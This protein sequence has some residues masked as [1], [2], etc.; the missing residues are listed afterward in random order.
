MGGDRQFFSNENSGFCSGWQGLSTS[1]EPDTLVTYRRNFQVPQ[2][3]RYYLQYQTHFDLQVI[4]PENTC[5]P[6]KYLLL[7]NEIPELPLQLNK[8]RN[9]V[10][11][12]LRNPTLKPVPGDF[13]AR[14][15]SENGTIVF[16]EIRCPLP[17]QQA[18]AGEDDQPGLDGFTPATGSAYKSCG[19]FGYTKGDGIL[20]CSMAAF[21]MITRP[22]VSGHPAFRKNVIW[23]L[24]LLPEGE[25]HPC[26]LSE[27][28]QPEAGETLQ[29]DWA[30]VRWGRTLLNG[31]RM[32][33]D[34]S[35]LTPEILIETEAKL[36]HLNELQNFGGYTRITLP[37]ESGC[38]T[39]LH[40]DGLFYDRTQDGPL[41]QNWLLFSGS[42]AFPEIPAQMILRNPPE[43]ITLRRQENGNISGILLEFAGP[44]EWAMLVFP[45]GLELF[46]PEQLDETWYEKTVALCA[47]RQQLALARPVACEDWFRATP[48][49]VEI[50]QKF[51]YRFLPDWLNTPALTA[52][53]LPPPLAIAG[54]DVPGLLLDPRAISLDF[55]SKYGPLYGV[56]NSTWS[57]YTLPLPCPRRKISFSSDSAGTLSDMISRDF[58]DFLSYHLDA[59]EIGNPGNYSFVFQYSFVLLVSHL[60]KKE[61]KERLLAIIRSGLE[62]VCNPE[63]QYRGPGGRQCCSW[64]L[65]RE[66][67]S[68]VSYYSTYL[69]VG[70]IS[71]YP[72]A[73]RQTIENSR[74]PFIE[75]DWGNAMSLYGTWL[76]TLFT[77]SWELIRDHWSVLRKA[78]DYYLV[79]MDW[80]CMTT[81]YAENGI[82]WNDG[83][84]YGGYLGFL[85]MAEMLGKEEDLALARYAYGKMFAMRTGLV[86]SARKYFCSFFGVPP[87]RTSKFFH[88]ELDA[89][90]AFQNYP[91]DLLYNGYRS[92]SLYNMT[93]E[94][95]YQETWNAYCQYMPGEIRDLLAAVERANP[96]DSITGPRPAGAENLY[97]TKDRVLGWQ[98]VMTYLMLCFIS[99]RFDR[100]TLL[101]KLREAAA[102]Q[103]IAQEFLGHIQWSKRRVPAAWTYAYLHT[104]FTGQNQPALTAWKNLSLA[105]AAYPEIEVAGTGPHAW[106]EFFSE[107]PVRVLLNGSE[108][109]LEVQSEN[110]FRVSVA[111][112]GIIVFG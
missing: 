11:I 43:K 64:Y 87:Y 56:L 51:T 112:D 104:T 105:R 39:R 20:D 82:T 89:T 102:N 92:Q 15:I 8:G 100:D 19:R 65:R 80:A 88:E 71:R 44:A 62:K 45:S 67:F 103:R 110:I 48:D 30:G 34:Y 21:G 47:R 97:H 10:E 25:P 109:P 70:G 76:G 54:E 96:E 78:F 98:E 38:L 108:L 18:A 35:L 69:H 52:A 93:T 31:Q 63:Y 107:K 59:P 2:T 5:R 3:D 84:N 36:L 12:Q 66:P 81:A 28:Y 91:S 37:L 60:L 29:V 74:W 40:S 6:G 49:S 68:G 83:T 46:Y 58:A 4:L 16:Q 106:L 13:A 41:K 7:H 27:N 101:E 61:E 53:P 86:Y 24:S 9:T 14:L 95:H 90:R 23:H 33:L 57:S 17:P 42:G 111:S 85:N 26:S 94:G 55:P 72:D 1:I 32:T 50:R 22:Y 73:G 77:G 79:M 99:R 75:I